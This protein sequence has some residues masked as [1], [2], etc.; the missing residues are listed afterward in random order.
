MFG[1]CSFIEN[2]LFITSKHIGI[3]L[4]IIGTILLALS[5]K[6]KRQY[7]GEMAKTIERLKKENDLLRSP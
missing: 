1:I 7:K 2:Q 3:I 6:V 5:V 4:T